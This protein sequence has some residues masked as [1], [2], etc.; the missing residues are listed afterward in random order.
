MQVFKNMPPTDTLCVFVQGVLSHFWLQLF[1]FKNP[2]P[3]CKGQVRGRNGN[4][5]S[6]K[7]IPGCM[8]HTRPLLAT[9]WSQRPKDKAHL[10]VC[11]SLNTSLTTATSFQVSIG[12]TLGVNLPLTSTKL[13][14]L[15]TDW[16]VCPMAPVCFYKNTPATSALDARYP[17]M[18]PSPSSLELPAASIKA[19]IYWALYMDGIVGR[20]VPEVGCVVK[21]LAAGSVNT[22]RALCSVCRVTCGPSSE[23]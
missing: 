1:L 19:P 16:L 9:W 4:V 14:S 21:R 5:A 11:L 2:S 22:P 3:S 10:S 18:H 12:V 7:T 6:R 23:R 17:S 8:S 20:G 15:T 13:T